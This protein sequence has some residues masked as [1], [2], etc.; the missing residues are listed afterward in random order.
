MR[1]IGR[2]GDSK[3]Q[4]H[5]EYGL[6]N[7]KTVI[8]CATASSVMMEKIRGHIKCSGRWNRLAMNLI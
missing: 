4:D 7:G 2:E 6:N 5:C 8:C 3:E 1:Q